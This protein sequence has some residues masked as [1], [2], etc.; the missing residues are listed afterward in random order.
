MGC[1]VGELRCA[2]FDDLAEPLGVR[3]ERTVAN[4][5]ENQT[6]C[7]A[8]LAE[9]M[10]STRFAIFDF[11]GSKMASARGRGSPLNTHREPIEDLE[12]WQ[13]ELG[14][15][16]DAEADERVSIESVRQALAAI[17]GSMAAEVSAE[18]DER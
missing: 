16:I 13:S 6:G 4:K 5:P 14:K 17:P 3:V 1:P 12:F 8:C 9:L 10:R 7:Q 15:Y 2:D 11:G 18:R